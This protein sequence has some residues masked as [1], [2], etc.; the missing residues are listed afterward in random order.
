MCDGLPVDSWAS[1]GRNLVLASE[2]SLYPSRVG[3]G[4]R[5]PLGLSARLYVQVD[6]GVIAVTDCH[7]EGI[8]AVDICTPIAALN[9]R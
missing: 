7:D 1:F 6:N 4:D 3:G 8:H 5:F 2:I 9:T